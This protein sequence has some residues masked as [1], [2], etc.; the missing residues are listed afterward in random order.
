MEEKM[1]AIKKITR[2]DIVN[3]ALDVLRESGFQAVNARNVAKKLGCSTQP[4]YLSFRNMEELKA[5]MTQRAIEAHTEKVMAAIRRNDGSH[6]R[7]CDYGI[8]FIRFAEH[9]KQLFRWIYL[10]DGQKGKRRSDVNLPG[11]IRVITDEYGYDEET[12]KK[13]HRDMTYFSYGLAVIASTDGEKLS[14]EE[15]QSALNREFYALVSI[16][17]IPPKI[18]QLKSIIEKGEFLK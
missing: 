6:S 5:E 10:E 13:L 11:I 2:E 7:Y 3:A 9:E 1:P 17:G 8:G 12:A 15:L 16:Y 14:D 18:P 4:I